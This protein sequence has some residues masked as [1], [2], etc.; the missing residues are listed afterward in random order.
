MKRCPTCRRDY[1]DETLK[2]CLDDG[3]MLVDGPRSDEGATRILPEQLQEWSGSRNTGGQNAVTAVLPANATVSA[4]SRRLFWIAGGLV[5]AAVLV[6]VYTYILLAKE[7]GNIETANTAKV[8]PRTTLYWE[9]GNEEELSFIRERSKYVQGLIGDE[10]VDLDPN[11]LRV[12]QVEIDDYVEERD[13]LSQV[14][15][16]EGL[17]VI[18]GRATQFASIVA[19]AFEAHR[20]PAAVGIYQAMIES[21]Y[22]DCPSHEHSG[23]PVGLFQFKRETAAKYG[24]TP[25]DYCNVQKQA[26]AAAQYMSDLSSDFGSEESSWTLAL[27]SFNSGETALRVRL[28]DLRARGV[29]ERTYWALL[30][31]RPD[32]AEDGDF[33]YVPRFF[34]AAIIGE[35]PAAFDLSTPPLTTLR[36]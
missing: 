9:L 35:T 29:T 19:A 30:R 23:A 15:F 21:E 8:P 33:R 2:F 25:A 26:D 3:T 34:A 22:H 18:Y 31:D 20:V 27:H 5:V 17:R 12:I 7:S 6:G 16:E 13:S 10:P 28:R 36:K 11:A 32:L 4:G 14:P 24:L 1:Y